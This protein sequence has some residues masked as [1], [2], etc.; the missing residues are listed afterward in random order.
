MHSQ[1][2]FHLRTIFNKVNKTFGLVRKLRNSLPRPSLSSLYK[3]F[4]R[5]HLD[6][7]YIICDQSFNYSFQN[8]IESIQ[9]NACLA[10]TGTIRRTSEERLYEE[11]GPFNIVAA[12]GKLVTFTKL[13]LTKPQTYLF[14]FLF[15][16][17]YYENERHISLPVF[18]VSKAIF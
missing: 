15:H 13:Q 7:R 14:Y 17:P 6:Y 4:I 18:A 16:C 2:S 5:T 12:I 3:S 11:E 8:K 1:L 10:I 9:Y